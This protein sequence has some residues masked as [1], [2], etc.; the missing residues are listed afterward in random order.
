MK[1]IKKQFIILRLA[2]IRNPKKRADYLKKKNLFKDFGNNCWYQPIKIP[3]QPKLV[4]IGNN[5]KIATD[6][7]F[8]EH[9]I[10]HDMFNGKNSIDYFREY[11]GTITIGNNV[12]IGARSIILY[13]TKIGNNCV[14]AAGSVITHDIPDNSIV[15]GCR[16]KLLAI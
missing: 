11:L 4:K 7:L 1:N 9:D 10:I 12:F 3:T 14:I 15:G 13:N 6:V 16:L 8:M 2:L 5:V